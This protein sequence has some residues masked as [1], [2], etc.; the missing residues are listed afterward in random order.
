MMICTFPSDLIQNECGIASMHTPIVI[1]CF[2]LV[3]LTKC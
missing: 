1:G 3:C 2:K